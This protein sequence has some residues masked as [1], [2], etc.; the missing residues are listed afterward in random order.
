[1][2]LLESTVAVSNSC[3]W[4]TSKRHLLTRYLLQQS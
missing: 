1:M 4:K 3:R 2:E